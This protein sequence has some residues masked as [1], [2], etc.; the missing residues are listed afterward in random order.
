MIFGLAKLMDDI[1]FK[2]EV[3]LFAREEIDGAHALEVRHLLSHVNL[4]LNRSYFLSEIRM[5]NFQDLD[6]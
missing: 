3:G 6:A 4:E 1:L 5:L 2:E